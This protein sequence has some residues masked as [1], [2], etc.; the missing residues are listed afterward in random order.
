MQ[1]VK[2]WDGLRAEIAKYCKEHKI[3]KKEFRFLGMY[4]WE[5]VYLLLED[6]SNKYW[7]AECSP[8][9]IQFLGKG[10]DVEVIKAVCKKES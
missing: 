10:L 2:K 5:K 6:D 8:D 9:V 3:S 4:E 7:V 1:I